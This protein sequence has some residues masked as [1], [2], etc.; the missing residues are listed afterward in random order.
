MKDEGIKFPVY[1]RYRNGRSYFKIL[2][3][4][5]FEEVQIIGS[6]RIIKEITAQQ[7]PEKLF[8]KDLLFDYEDRA[9]SISEAEYEA[10][11]NS[12]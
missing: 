5:A 8:V 2:N 1:R 12:T 9:E 4:L 7:Y 10:A 3:E 11:K 6:R